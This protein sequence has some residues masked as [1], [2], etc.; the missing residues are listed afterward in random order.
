MGWQGGRVTYDHVRGYTL[1]VDAAHPSV[2][3]PDVIV[4][5]TY[6]NPDTRGHSN[7]NKLQLKLGELALLKGAFPDS[8][9]R[10]SSGTYQDKK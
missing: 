5:V 10:F 2:A 7:E 6:T 1:Q 9:M 8:R 4:S 3:R